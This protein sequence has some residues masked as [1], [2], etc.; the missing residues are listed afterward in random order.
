MAK[1]VLPAY[2][3]ELDDADVRR[4]L[5]QRFAGKYEIRPSR[6]KR[7]ACLVCASDWKGAVVA[8]RQ[9]PDEEQTVVMVFGQVPSV[10]ARI[11]L[12]VIVWFPLLY[13]Q[14][15]G[16]RPVAQDVIHAIETSPELG[17]TGTAAPPPP[18][19]AASA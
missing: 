16:S 4:I 11:A 7:V 15:I 9:K 6:S 19:T 1:V 3:P 17:G 13:M 10:W 12:V 5:E 2:K 8:L 14:T 18:P